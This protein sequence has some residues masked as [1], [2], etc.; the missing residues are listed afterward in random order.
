MIKNYL[1][2]ALRALKRRKG[3]AFF[4]IAGLAIGFAACLVIG[5]Y[6]RH[7]T[8]YDEFHEKAER[9]FRVNMKSG[10][11]GASGRIAANAVQPIAERFPE[12]VDY[13][14]LYPSGEIIVSGSEPVAEDAFY[15]A[16]PSFFDIFSFSL[17]KGNPRTA[18]TEPNTVVL[19]EET[20]TRYF[21]EENALEKTLELR[22]GTILRVTGVLEDVPSNSHLQFDLLASFSTL[23]APESE[24]QSAMGYQSHTYFLLAEPAAAQHL[25]RKLS[26]MLSTESEGGMDE[27]Y[28]WLGFAIEGMEVQLQPI[29][30]IHL[31]PFFGGMI[32]P[33]NS[34][35]TL[36][37]FGCIALFVLLL[38]CVNYI[39][40]STAR[41]AQRAK[42]VG[43]RKVVGAGRAQLAR[44]FLG[45][46]VITTFAAGLLALLLARILLRGFN[47]LMRLELQFA[48][49]GDA[50]LLGLLIGVLLLVSLLA[51]GYPALVLSRFRPAEVLK[52][53][54][55][56]KIGGAGLR[57]GLV[58]FQFAVSIVI[59]V[60][61][62]VAHSQIRF[63]DDMPRG[64]ETEAIVSIPLPSGVQEQAETLKREVMRLP[65]VES[66]SLAQGSPMS[67]FKLSVEYEGEEISVKS[68]AADADYLETMRMTLVAGEGFTEQA[69]SDSIMAVIANE[70]AAKIFSL[71][72]DVSEPLTVNLAYG[73]QR[74]A[75]IVSDFHSGSFREPTG[76][77]VI[78]SWPRRQNTLV[79]RLDQARIGT[80]LPAL[81]RTWEQFTANVPFTYHF[82][83][84]SL[85]QMYRNEARLANLSTA[86]AFLAILI[87]CFGLFGLAAFAAEKRTKEIGI[88]KV[89]GASVPKLVGLLSKD[90]LKLVFVAFLIAAPLAYFAMQKWLEDFAYRIELGPW[91]FLGAGILVVLIALGTVSYQAVR[92]ALA[93]PVEA[94][95]NE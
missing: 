91:L 45:E 40:L 86:F 68:I 4:N 49:F 34:A 15:Y 16:D 89:L 32:Q 26:N 18:L 79:L 75:G 55:R 73:E 48:Y 52:G 22:D 19:T 25:N 2:I 41:A 8:S 17:E 11:L 33:V 5:L 93:D 6:L 46:A 84:E 39:N 82:L 70:T 77:M 53:S 94:L 90:F 30:A 43:M 65:G 1:T 81:E 36:Y 60:G 76:P 74:L 23:P 59:V 37:I 21:S 38:A 72:D 50:S 20:A 3:Y 78:Y 64:Y 29:T 54:S 44:Q 92:A 35:S 61:A 14:R 85:A 10:D 57:K 67:Y 62:L 58:V 63:M 24:Y 66:A 80:A 69:A 95:R 12:V 9:I 7:E 71:Y 42:E 56:G 51:G 31:Q 87:A 13:V 47:A 27:A 28:N 88:R 83:D